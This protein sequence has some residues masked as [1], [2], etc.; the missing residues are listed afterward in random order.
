MRRQHI[1]VCAMCNWRSSAVNSL[2]VLFAAERLRLARFDDFTQ[3]LRTI[4]P[5]AR[6]QARLM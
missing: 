2:C 6:H 1:D 5:S 3:P 4:S